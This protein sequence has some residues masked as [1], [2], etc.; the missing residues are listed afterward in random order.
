MKKI[1]EF[2]LKMDVISV[3]EDKNE[4]VVDA[5]FIEKVEAL[6]IPELD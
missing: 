4:E 3:E 5:S 1:Q 6:P 2:K